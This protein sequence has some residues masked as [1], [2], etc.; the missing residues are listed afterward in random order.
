MMF[1]KMS[2]NSNKLREHIEVG[3]QFRHSSI[4]KKHVLGV[5][6]QGLGQARTFSEQALE[7]CLDLERNFFARHLRGVTNWLVGTQ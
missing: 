6:H 2:V 5:K 7:D 3:R 1:G 4:E